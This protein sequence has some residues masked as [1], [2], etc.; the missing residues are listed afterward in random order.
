MDG[1]FAVTRKYNKD[2]HFGSYLYQYTDKMQT[3]LYLPRYLYLL[4][5]Y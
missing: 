5:I 4:D 3:E 2:T 1:G